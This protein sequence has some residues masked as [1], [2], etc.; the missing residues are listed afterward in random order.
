MNKP[1]KLGREFSRSVLFLNLK[2]RAASG[3]ANRL[4][5]EF[6][7]FQPLVEK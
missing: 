3:N 1:I 7:S 5:I 4:I 6:M 2:H